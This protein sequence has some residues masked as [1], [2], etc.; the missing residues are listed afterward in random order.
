MNPSPLPEDD[1][2]FVAERVP[3]DELRGGRVLVAGGTGFFGHWIVE[4][5]LHAI[6]L[7]GL[8]TEVV[9]LARSPGRLARHPKL[10]FIQGDV[11]NFGFPRAEISHVVH[12]A[13][14]TTLA[15]TP[16]NADQSIDT[17]VNGTRRLL[18]LARERGVRKFLLA[19][20][21]AVYGPQPERIE[22][23]GEA[24]AGAPSL[25][26]AIAPYAEAK[27]VAEILV[28]RTT[29]LD[30]TIAR[31]FAFVGPGLPLDAHFAAGNFLRDALARRPI[32]IR[33][34]ATAV[35]SYLYAADLAV[36]LWTIL[37]RGTGVYNVGSEREV[38]IH[39]LAT[40]VAQETGT[41]VVFAPCPSARPTSR[42][43]VPDTLRARESL[44]LEETFCLRD[45]VR[46]TVRYH[47]AQETIH[48]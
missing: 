20:S 6:D 35:R 37:L 39:D 23:I 44:G 3:W 2:R 24:F 21:G 14:D 16:A 31:G 5:L 48:A 13:A 42:R 15:P 36:W 1:L 46:R 26:H 30:A 7:Y 8:D 33:G 19:S 17:V 29:G 27:R 9:V 10:F 11:R 47:K 12:L 34:D 38:A 25:D 45:A 4:S 41:R 32:E 43:Y 28:G 40:L 18:R 22:R